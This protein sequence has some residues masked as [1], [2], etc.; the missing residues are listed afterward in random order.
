[1]LRAAFAVTISLACL[2]VPARGQG[3]RLRTVERFDPFQRASL[4]FSRPPGFQVSHLTWRADSVTIPRTYWLE[5]GVIGGVVLGLLGSGLCAYGARPPAIA[6]YL[7]VFAFVGGGIG[8]PA[9]A[10]I[11]GLFPKG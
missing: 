3:P 9:G 7:V 5:G 2:A 4:A 10:L 1:M 11:G 8:F 6:C